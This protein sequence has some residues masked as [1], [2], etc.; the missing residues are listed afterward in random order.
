MLTTAPSND[1]TTVL[2]LFMHKINYKFYVKCPL[3]FNVPLVRVYMCRKFGGYG[4]SGLGDYATF[5]FLQIS[6]LDYGL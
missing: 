2:A 3:K 5:I 6:L 1:F 4:S